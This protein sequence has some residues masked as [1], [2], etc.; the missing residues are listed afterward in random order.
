MAE[1]ESR[2][3]GFNV[4]YTLSTN[5]NTREEMVSRLNAVTTALGA[6]WDFEPDSATDEEIKANYMLL[7]SAD[8]AYHALLRDEG[9]MTFD[10][11]G[12]A[13]GH[14]GKDILKHD[15]INDITDLWNANCP[16]AKYKKV[17]LQGF[18]LNTDEVITKGIV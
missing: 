1:L 9:G 7:S 12:I 6:G 5:S 16:S 14:G 2:Q 17:A 4:G 3:K 15:I 11:A 10:M 18:Y 13:P 8:A